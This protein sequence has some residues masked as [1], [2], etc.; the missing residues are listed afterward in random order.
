MRRVGLN[1]PLCTCCLTNYCKR[2]DDLFCMN[3][4]NF[5]YKKIHLNANF[6]SREL[7]N[8]YYHIKYINRTCSLCNHKPVISYYH[9][10]LKKRYFLCQN[11]LDRW[12]KIGAE[13]SK[14]IELIEKET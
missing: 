1:K 5:I 9:I 11:H 2:E 7:K 10:E 3:C 13:L 12:L 14:F 4:K 6:V 8:S